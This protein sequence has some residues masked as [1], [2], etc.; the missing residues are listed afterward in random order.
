M[1]KKRRKRKKRKRGGETS[2]SSKAGASKSA[3]GG[4]VMQSMRAGFRR[5]A[6][7]ENAKGDDKPS[8]LSN[9][10]WTVVLLAAVGFL[11]YRWY[12]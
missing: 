1:A 10:L 9:V 7:A 11:L 8:T 12:G 4:G 3:T 2:S 5:A 6:G